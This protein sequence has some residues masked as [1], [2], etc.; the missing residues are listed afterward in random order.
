M[1]NQSN[2]NGN[3]LNAVTN[4]W[5]CRKAFWSLRGIYAAVVLVVKY[6]I[7][8]IITNSF[9]NKLNYTSFKDI[10][11]FLIVVLIVID[12][13]LISQF[14]KWCYVALKVNEDESIIWFLKYV[15]IRLLFQSLSSM[16]PYLLLFGH[17]NLSANIK[18]QKE[19]NSG[20]WVA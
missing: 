1:H 19:D 6:S 8:F 13:N 14:D 3:L 18:V 2:I 7:L 11:L 17:L 10:V 15:K 5:P 12:V 4:G 16:F 20:V 9:S